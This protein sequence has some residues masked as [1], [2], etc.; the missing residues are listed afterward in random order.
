MKNKK[1]LWPIIFFLVGC[2]M[3]A[4]G[5][6]VYPTVYQA[7]IHT[8][9]SL[10]YVGHYVR[11]FG[12]YLAFSLRLLGAAVAIVSFLGFVFH[13]KLQGICSIKTSLVAVGISGFTASGMFAALRIADLMLSNAF[14]PQYSYPLKEP[15]AFAGGLIS[16]LGVIVLWWLYVKFRGKSKSKT[17]TFFD[18]V[19]AFLFIPGFFCA[20]IVVWY[21]LGAVYGAQY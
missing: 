6:F 2:V 18:V 3:S 21:Y 7:L 10:K 20:A 11:D 16:G 4:I 13:E 14:D 19:T 5:W 15:A 17:G 9:R 8:T 1:L 12:W